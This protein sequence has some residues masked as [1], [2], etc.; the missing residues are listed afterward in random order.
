MCCFINQRPIRN[1]DGAYYKFVF[2]DRSN[3]A[4]PFKFHPL[5]SD[6][7]DRIQKKNGGAGLSFQL[8]FRC[9]PHFNGRDRWPALTGASYHDRS[10]WL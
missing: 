5:I 6:D 1:L 9:P 8:L 4:R 10:I 3:H 2:K 7:D